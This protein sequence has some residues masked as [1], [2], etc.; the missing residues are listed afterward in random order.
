MEI[1]SMIGEVTTQLLFPCPAHCRMIANLLDMAILIVPSPIR[2]EIYHIPIQLGTKAGQTVIVMNPVQDLGQQV[3]MIDTKL[4]SPTTLKPVVSPA[5][6][7]YN[8][9]TVNVGSGVFTFS[10]T[11]SDKYGNLVPNEPIL[12]KMTSGEQFNLTTNAVGQTSTLPF[13]PRGS[14][15][16]VN[17]TATVVST[18]SINTTFSLAFV[19]TNPTMSLFVVPL[20]MSSLDYVPPTQADVVVSVRD[21]LGNPIQGQNITLTLDYTSGANWTAAPYLGPILRLIT[22]QQMLRER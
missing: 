13:G 21:D 19:N 6:S 16:T 4:S 10:F 5:L 7:Q 2:M 9:S 8:N 18:P 11:L 12:V 3:F 22:E 15:Q 20:D 14:A 1:L 17:V